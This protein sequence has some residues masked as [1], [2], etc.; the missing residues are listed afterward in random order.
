[1]AAAAV[2]LLAH[3][4]PAAE[5][6]GINEF[7][8]VN[9]KTLRDEDG[10]SSDWIE[11]YNAGSSVLSL[12]GWYLTDRAYDSQRWAF[13]PTNLPS[14]RYLVVF[15]SGK[16]RALAGR[17]LHTDFKLD[18][19]GG[20]LALYHGATQATVFAAYA[21]QELD[22]SYGLGD[23]G[24]ARYFSVPTPGASNNLARFTLASPVFSP[25]GGFFTQA[26]AVTMTSD[27]AG[28]EIYYTTDG[29]QPAATN[30]LYAGPLTVLNPTP[31]RAI[32]VKNGYDDSPDMTRSFIV[33]NRA[34]TLPV[35]LI[36]ARPSDLFG[37][38]GIYDAWASY[39]EVERECYFEYFETGGARAVAIPAGVVIH[40]GWSRNYP[41]KS[42]AIHA[43]AA[44]GEGKLRHRFFAGK[45]IDEFNSILLRNSGTDWGGTMMRDALIQ[46]LTAGPM[47]VDYQAYQPCAAFINGRY[48]GIYNVREKLTERYC[49]ENYGVSY[50]N[51]DMMKR[52]GGLIVERG[53]A[54]DYNNLNGY[55]T[56]QDMT[57]QACY[58]Y[59]ATQMDIDNF[60]DY[61][62]TEMYSGNIDWPQNQTVASE[63][64][65]AWHTVGFPAVSVLARLF[66]RF[67]QAPTPEANRSQRNQGSSPNRAVP[68][69][70]ASRHFPAL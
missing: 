45:D 23:S 46:T 12:G 59:V 11:L 1:L 17:P 39:Q 24:E 43:R 61:Q 51:V 8:A 22:I 28:A 66:V 55:V 47:D 65:M 42:L 36:S 54:T 27:M 3:A 13:P 16:D 5:D 68:L 20:Y 53:S 30:T 4:T 40:G 21:R 50:T 6:I 29:S 19:G 58:D 38:S 67:L 56:T 7:M 37:A 63:D 34:F 64:R 60:L 25:D 62:I 48:W 10:S 49:E 18:G 2:G 9:G 69:L 33:T 35:A 14:H 41:A 57:Q 26:V 44:Y 70:R 32:A 15:A 31:L 52:Q